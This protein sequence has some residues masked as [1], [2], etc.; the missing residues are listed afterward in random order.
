MNIQEEVKVF[1]ENLVGN[2]VDKKN[3]IN[4]DVS[5]STKT[6]L[7]QIKTAKEDCGKVIGRK[8]RTIEAIKI[9]T[10]AFKNTQFPQ[11]SKNISIEIIEGGNVIINKKNHG[12]YSNVKK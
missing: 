8:G 5:I 2:L 10:L 3:D 12:D 7:V 4:V 11:D 9:L 6:I 1:V